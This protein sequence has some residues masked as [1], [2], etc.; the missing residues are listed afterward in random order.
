MST[1]YPTCELVATAYSGF[2]P[3]LTE[4]AV[5]IQSSSRLTTRSQQ[6]APVVPAYWF[7]SCQAALWS[8]EFSLPMQS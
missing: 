3:R 7:Y 6:P 4:A 8:G 1:L 5:T 2:G